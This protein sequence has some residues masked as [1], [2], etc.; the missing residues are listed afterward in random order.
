[1][2]SRDIKLFLIGINSSNQTFYSTNN[3]E[4]SSFMENASTQSFPVANSSSYR[5]LRNRRIQRRLRHG[6]IDTL[7]RIRQLS[8]QNTMNTNNQIAGLFFNGSTFF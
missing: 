5:I 3:C 4:E 2:V 6:N 1:M 7:Y 8:R